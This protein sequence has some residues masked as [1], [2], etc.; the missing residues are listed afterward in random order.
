MKNAYSTVIIDRHKWQQRWIS[1]V[2]IGVYFWFCFCMRINSVFFIWCLLKVQLITF[3]DQIKW[4]TTYLRLCVAIMAPSLILWIV[5][6]K[7]TFSSQSRLK[8]KLQLSELY[9]YFML[10]SNKICVVFDNVWPKLW[11]FSNTVQQSLFQILYKLHRELLLLY[12]TYSGA[13]L[14]PVHKK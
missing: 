14:I 1:T 2:E 7:Y 12:G 13:K 9:D 5:E 4:Y 8:R 6:S 10:L 3:V 11:Y